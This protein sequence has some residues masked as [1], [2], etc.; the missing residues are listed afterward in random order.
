MLPLK[1]RGRWLKSGYWGIPHPGWTGRD[2]HTKIDKAAV[3]R[4]GRGGRRGGAKVLG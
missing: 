3:G 4:R 1:L 2:I